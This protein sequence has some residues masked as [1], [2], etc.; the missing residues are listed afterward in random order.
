LSHLVYLESM[1]RE[2]LISK[3]GQ[4]I[5]HGPSVNKFF[6]SCFTYHTSS[7]NCTPG[8]VGL[9]S[10]WAVSLKRQLV[11]RIRINLIRIRI[12]HFRLNTDDQKWGKIYSKKR[13]K[14]FWIKNYE[15]TIPRPLERTSKLQKKP[16]AL[17]REHSAL[18][19]RKFLNFF[20]FCG[21]FLSSWIR[22]R[23]PNSDPDKDQLT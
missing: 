22:I 14:N 7:K 15:T 1:P 9:L 20:Y 12:Q 10:C 5:I 23:I 6:L 8:E 13:I 17:Q 21:S 16:S 11:F 19:N 4:N 18:H 3:L 2:L